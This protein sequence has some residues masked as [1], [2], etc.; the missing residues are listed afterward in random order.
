[1]PLHSAA[2]TEIHQLISSRILLMLGKNQQVGPIAAALAALLCPGITM[3][4]A[5]SLSSQLTKPMEQAAGKVRS[6]GD[7]I[8][9]GP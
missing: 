1:M 5:D 4:W 7:R 8:A 9:H 3:L 2:L 6:G